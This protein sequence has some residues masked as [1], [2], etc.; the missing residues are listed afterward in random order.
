MTVVLIWF[1]RETG[2]LKHG[3][4]VKKALRA[5]SPFRQDEYITRG[6][7]WVSMNLGLSFLNLPYFEG[8]E[9]AS[10]MREKASRTTIVVPDRLVFNLEIT[11]FI[12][13]LKVLA[14]SCIHCTHLRSPF[15]LAV[16]CD[17]KQ[18]RGGSET[19]AILWAPIRFRAWSHPQI[20][21]LAVHNALWIREYVLSWRTENPRS[22]EKQGTLAETII[23]YPSSSRFSSF[24]Y[25]N[26]VR[27]KWSNE[28][29]KGP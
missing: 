9:K 17:G 1:V 10:K 19:I 29:Q 22:L 3:L 18:P 21:L 26:A 5:H 15:P 12:S 25:N 16:I 2:N 23:C 14:S 27:R 4:A 8:L 7:T 24:A 11:P 13:S 20:Y 6:S 28:S